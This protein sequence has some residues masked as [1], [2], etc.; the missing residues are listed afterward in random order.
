MYNS[1]HVIGNS[2]KS[3]WLLYLFDGIHKTS[4]CKCL[5]HFLCE[6]WQP[7]IY[8]NWRTYEIINP[9]VTKAIAINVSYVAVGRHIKQENYW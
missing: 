2:R 5:Y 3:A 9:F 7:Q 1:C 8:K 4:A 6:S